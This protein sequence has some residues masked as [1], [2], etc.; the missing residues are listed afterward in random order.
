MPVLKNKLV[1]T[2]ILKILHM[3]LKLI[4]TA[5]TALKTVNNFFLQETTPPPFVVF[6]N[7]V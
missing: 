2:K 3:R 7:Q 4:L 5:L 1:F 6:R